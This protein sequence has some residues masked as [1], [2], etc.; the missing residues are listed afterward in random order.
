MKRD[1]NYIR[2]LLLTIEKGGDLHAYI[3]DEPQQAAQNAEEYERQLK[4]YE[5]KEAKFFGHLELLIESGFIKGVLISKGLDRFHSW[6]LALPSPRL[7]MSGHDL[8][9]T[10]RS[11][12]IWESIKSIARD[13]KIELTF[14]VIKAL[15]KIALAK[16]VGV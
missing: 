6:G 2:E 7:T 4:E 10:M 9:D 3:P 14:D 5:A 15:A 16:L 8:L 11:S 12:T 1:W 13:K